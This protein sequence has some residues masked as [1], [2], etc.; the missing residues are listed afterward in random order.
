MK[1]IPDSIWVECDLCW[2]INPD[3]FNSTCV[4]CGHTVCLKCYNNENWRCAVCG[5]KFESSDEIIKKRN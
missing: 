3:Y 4:K 2:D 1:R 5:G